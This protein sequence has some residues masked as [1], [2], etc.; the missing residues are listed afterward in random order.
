MNK[1]LALDKF[2]GCLVGLSVGDAIGK[3]VETMT[4]SA[5]IAKNGPVGITGYTVNQQ[6]RIIGTMNL[7]PGAVTDDTRM[8]FAVA[9][10]L[11]ARGRFDLVDQSKELVA[12]YNHRNDFGG[13][14]RAAEETIKQLK[15]WF[16]TNGKFGRHPSMPALPVGL[17]G[18]G[19]GNG[20]AVKIAPLALFYAVECGIMPEPFVI[21]AIQL[22]QMTHADR[23]ASIAAVALGTMVACVLNSDPHFPNFRPNFSS[24]K[25]L[26]QLIQTSVT[27]R[28][29]KAEKKE[30][31]FHSGK[32]LLSSRLEILWNS[33]NS[34]DELR[35]KIGTKGFALESV[36][37][38][39]GTFFRH[40]TNFREGIL[41]AVNAGGDTDS[42][43]SMVGA[44][45]GANMGLSGIPAEW[46]RD[47]L[48][49]EEA[50]S[51]ADELAKISGAC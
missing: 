20:V 22:G 43:A 33:L 49:R 45:I 26:T 18:E 46:T 12:E 24:E 2:R 30:P 39:I 27:C 16:E 8:A 34:A 3:C 32:E 17:P 19:C 47:L 14:S 10:S 40:P 37:F 51:L 38:A 6:Q 13:F 31:T 44:T 41:E 9:R 48:A 15:L 4:R 23:R 1:L 50:I 25:F 21:N 35:T 7:P 42:S 11:I 5:I 29:E 36:P 28:V